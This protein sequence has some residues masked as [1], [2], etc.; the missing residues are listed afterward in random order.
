[1]SLDPIACV[2]SYLRS[3]PDLYQVVVTGD[4][5]AREVGD[6]TV[7]VEHDGG[8]RRDRD[9]EVDRVY[10]AYEVYSLDREEAAELSF[11]V[12]NLLL[13]GLRN[14]V[15]VGDLYFLDSR[16]EEMPDYEP[17]DTSREHAYCGVV[18]FY[19]QQA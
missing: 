15:T 1:M 3:Q 12:R 11:K 7:Y 8:Y 4:M 5:G 19:Y 2:V 16:D 13:R 18:S 6:T 10:V 14:G 17:D 9:A